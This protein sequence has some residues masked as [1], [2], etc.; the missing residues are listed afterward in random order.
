MRPNEGMHVGEEVELEPCDFFTDIGTLIIEGRL[1]C[2]GGKGFS[3]GPHCPP[4]FQPR[5]H[6]CQPDDIRCQQHEQL[7]KH[8][9]LL[10]KNGIPMSIEVLLYPECCQVEPA[11]ALLQVDTAPESHAFSML[12]EQWTLQMPQRRIPD[13]RISPRGLIQAVRSFL[14]FSQLSAWLSLGK[15]KIKTNVHYRVCVPGETFSNKFGTT[16]EEHNF[17]VSN[18]GRSYAARV[19]V[20][21]LPRLPQMPR[22]SC[23][24]HDL[25]SV[26]A[27]ASTRRKM[28]VAFDGPVDTPSRPSRA[29]ST[30]KERVLKEHSWGE[31]LLDP[32]QSLAMYPKRYQSP[33]RCGSPSLETPEHLLFGGMRKCPNIRS[34]PSRGRPQRQPVIERFLKKEYGLGNNPEDVR[35]TA[36]Y[37]KLQF[38]MEFCKKSLFDD[39]QSFAFPQ[40]DPKLEQPIS[41]FH[42]STKHFLEPNVKKVDKYSV[43]DSDMFAVKLNPEEVNLVLDQLRHRIEPPSGCKLTDEE[44][45]KKSLRFKY[46]DD[47]SANKNMKFDEKEKDFEFKTKLESNNAIKKSLWDSLNHSKSFEMLKN[48]LEYRDTQCNTNYASEHYSEPI[49]SQKLESPKGISRNKESVLDQKEELALRVC[50]PVKTVKSNVEPHLTNLQSKNDINELHESNGD[51]KQDNQNKRVKQN[52]K[53]ITAAWEPGSLNIASKESE[54]SLEMLLDLLEQDCAGPV[55]LKEEAALV[56]TQ[57]REEP[58]QVV[59]CLGKGRSLS[60]LYKL[61]RANANY[62]PIHDESPDR[63]SHVVPSAAEKLKFRRSL[64][65]ATSMVFHKKTGLPLTSS[66]APIRKSGTCFDFDS[67][68]TTVAA[69]KKALFEKDPEESEQFVLSQSAPASTTANNLLG[70]FEESVLNGRLEPVSTVEGFT[71]EIGASGAFC[72]RHRTFPVTVFFYSLYD[73]HNVTSPY[74]GHINLGRKGYNVPKKGTVQVTLFNPHGTVVKMFV[75]LYDLSDMPPNCQTFLR[76]RTLY[77][78]SGASEEH[79]HARKWLRY[80]IH[81]RFASSKSGKVYLHTDMRLIVFRKSDLDAAAVHGQRP[82][83]LR[84]FTQGPDKPKFSP[85]K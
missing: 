51:V 49:V 45:R 67:S 5:R 77:M 18:V 31:S 38:N 41:V 56:H 42:S 71:A 40:L 39:D 76:Q 60:M 75:V 13:G 43:C 63:N 74:L 9:R 25:A 72:P 83:E 36:E 47:S 61:L 27:M 68:L 1:P 17:P 20:R 26:G 37:G 12:L 28:Q 57:K 7:E 19:S 15:G 52:S 24:T 70:N 59:G 50:D 2:P 84:S 33:S 11:P 80:L 54:E 44:Y 55:T 29:T 10:W 81:L 64:D 23:P 4:P 21:S 78:P 34:A 6:V 53:Q 30:K 32:P 8:M 85:N 14:H 48:P 35:A 69:I 3:E 22:V 46:S 65:S 79:P 58:G 66:P 82:Y 73:T 62:L 16:P